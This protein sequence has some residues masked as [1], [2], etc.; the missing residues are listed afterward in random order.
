MGETLRAHGV[1]GEILVRGVSGDGGPLLALE[2]VYAARG[3]GEVRALR[4]A[5]ARRSGACVLLRF[6]GLESRE[7]V[8]RLSG[9][10]LLV[11]SSEAPALPEGS[12]YFFQL[13]GLRVTTEDGRDLGEI[14]DVMENPGN[15]VWVARGPAGE[16]LIPAVD[17]VVRR[18][19]VAAGRVVIDPLPGLLPE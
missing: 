6:E 19:D 11:P 2:R 17:A 10:Y 16:F 4:V 13:V 7:E 14:V 9:H 5:A 15:D 1:R 8:A 12:C 3:P 18:V